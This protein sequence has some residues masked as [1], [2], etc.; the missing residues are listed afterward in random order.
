MRTPGNASD[1]LKSK[2][3]S[4]LADREARVGV[5]EAAPGE[6]TVGDDEDDDGEGIGGAC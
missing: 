4:K 5:C 6:F 2:D 3:V 1:A